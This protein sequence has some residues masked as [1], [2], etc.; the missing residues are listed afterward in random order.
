MDYSVFV[1]P[2]HEERFRLEQ[3]FILFH[4]GRTQAKLSVSRVHFKKEVP[5]S[6]YS[7]FSL[8]D[9]I[10]LPQTAEFRIRSSSLTLD[11]N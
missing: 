11:R 10:S 3:C 6:L 4:D 8:I 7:L 5:L 2:D 9:L 1:V